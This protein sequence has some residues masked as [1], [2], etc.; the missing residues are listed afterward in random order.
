M[1]MRLAVIPGM[2]PYN[3]KRHILKSTPSPL[4]GEGWGEGD[5]STYSANGTA[6]DTRNSSPMLRAMCPCPVRSLGH[7]HVAGEHPHLR[8][9]GNLKLGDAVQIHHVLPPR[10]VVVVRKARRFPAANRYVAGADVVG[11]VREL[12]RRQVL[13]VALAVAAGINSYY[14]SHRI[15]SCLFANVVALPV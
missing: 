6:S 15:A 9:V 7:Q 10:R 12:V 4:T 13:K 11:N 2:N 1:E 8:S 5:R 14:L 3:H